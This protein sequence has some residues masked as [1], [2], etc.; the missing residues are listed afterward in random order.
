LQ[1]LKKKGNVLNLSTLFDQVALH[2]RGLACNTIVN[3]NLSLKGRRGEESSGQ[4]M[5]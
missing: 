2:S 3:A 4:T 5:I 1:Q